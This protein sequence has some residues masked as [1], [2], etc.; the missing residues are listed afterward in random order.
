MEK[1]E[2]LIK[3]EVEIQEMKGKFNDN[4]DGNNRGG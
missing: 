3:L 2:L 4:G 1:D